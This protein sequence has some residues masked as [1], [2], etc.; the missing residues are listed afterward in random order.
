MSPNVTYWHK[1]FAADS[2][3]TTKALLLLNS[4]KYLSLNNNSFQDITDASLSE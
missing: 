1:Y 2:S 4:Q 3:S